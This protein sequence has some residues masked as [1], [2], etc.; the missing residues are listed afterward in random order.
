[1][2]VRI[3][4][5]MMVLEL[6]PRESRWWVRVKSSCQYVLVCHEM[7]GKLEWRHSVKV[8]GLCWEIGEGHFS[9]TQCDNEINTSTIY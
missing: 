6:P 1:M 4:A 9:D 3:V 5:T 2:S 8:Y 7:R